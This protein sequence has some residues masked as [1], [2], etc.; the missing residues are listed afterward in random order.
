MSELKYNKNLVCHTHINLRTAAKY[1]LIIFF[2]SKRAFVAS[3]KNDYNRQKNFGLKGHD[4]NF[5]F[6]W[7]RSPLPRLWACIKEK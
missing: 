1:I 7:G 2:S 6:G 5:I 3:V 4:F